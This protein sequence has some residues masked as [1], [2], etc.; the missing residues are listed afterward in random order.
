MPSRARDDRRV[1]RLPVVATLAISA[2]LAVNLACAA[3]VTDTPD[4]SY[5]ADGPYLHEVIQPA[6]AR[7]HK[8]YA[9]LMCRASDVSATPLNVADVQKL[10][11][12]VGQGTGNLYDYFLNI[13]YGAVD[14]DG[15]QLYVGAGTSGL[16]TLGWYTMTTTQAQLLARTQT[17]RGLTDAECQAAAK[18]DKFD[19]SAY[20]GVISIINTPTDSGATG[21]D[22]VVGYPTDENGYATYMLTFLEHET[23]H[24]FGL[25][26]SMSMTMDTLTD[27]RWSPGGDTEYKDCW[28]IMSAVGCVYTFT[29]PPYPGQSG[30]GLEAAYREQQGWIPDPRIF[31]YDPTVTP[32]ATIVLAPVSAPRTPGSLIAKIP[33]GPAGY[34]T[35][36]FRTRADWDQALPMDAVLIHEMRAST[37]PGEPQIRSFLV[38]RYT[39]DSSIAT[40]PRID[41]KTG[42]AWRPGQVFQDTADHVRI[43]IDKFSGGSAT[44]TISNDVSATPGPGSG[45]GNG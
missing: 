26:H 36:E 20:A 41:P 35:V 3:T 10:F 1:Q 22:V 5:P 38:R 9:I 7:T 21:P 17:T 24:T 44:I 39:G 31:T 29:Q 37:I 25:V 45:G 23:L 42:S 13:T 34:Y 4:P 14:L 11:L 2:L 43:S 16:N 15:S 30:P 33:V 19:P 40:D 12:K 32:S 27:H 8:A 18:A 6:A 28:D